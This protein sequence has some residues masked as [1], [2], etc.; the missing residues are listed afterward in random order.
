MYEVIPAPVLHIS[1]LSLKHKESSQICAVGPPPANR[2]L[3]EGQEREVRKS[4]ISVIRDN[5]LFNRVKE[6]PRDEK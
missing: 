4:L 2:R 1:R 5:T 3:F 6:P